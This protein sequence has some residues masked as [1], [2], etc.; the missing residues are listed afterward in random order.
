MPYNVV[1]AAISGK[2]HRLVVLDSTN[3]LH[4]FKLMIRMPIPLGRRFLVK[5]GMKGPRNR[6]GSGRA[7]VEA[8]ILNLSF[9]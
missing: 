4:F 3:K 2:Y 9:P 5:S 7:L 1:N 8:M 6:S